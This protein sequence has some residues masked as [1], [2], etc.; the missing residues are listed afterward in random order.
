MKYEMKEFAESVLQGARTHMMQAVYSA[1]NFTN[2]RRLLRLSYR[3]IQWLR[4]LFSHKGKSK[5]VM[6]P[7]Y[8]TA[9]PVFPSVHDMKADEADMLAAHGDIDQQDDGRGAVCDRLTASSARPL[10]AHTPGGS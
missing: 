3:K 8:D 6:H 10:H 9:V 7:E 1:D 2:A 5:R 4:R